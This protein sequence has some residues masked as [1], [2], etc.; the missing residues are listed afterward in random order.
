MD[1]FEFTKNGKR[2]NTG[3]FQPGMSGNP[4]GRPKDNVRVRELARQCSPAAV[5]TL[6]E[7]AISPDAKPADRLRA[8]ESIINRV[9]GKAT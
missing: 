9:I 1:D 5:Q 2:R 6:F 3:M 4:N 8:S 7:I